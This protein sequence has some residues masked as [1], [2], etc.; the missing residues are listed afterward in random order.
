MRPV[1]E[2]KSRINVEEMDRFYCRDN[3]KAGLQ[4]WM[5]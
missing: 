2:S 4:G 5:S 1:D 3:S